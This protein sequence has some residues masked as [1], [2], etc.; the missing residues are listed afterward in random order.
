MQIITTTT[1]IDLIELQTVLASTEFS[2]SCNDLSDDYFTGEIWNKEI[3]VSGE[4]YSL[5]F[6][7]IV[8]NNYNRDTLIEDLKIYD[9]EGDEVEVEN[10]EEVVKYISIKF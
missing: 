2:G 9:S 7:Y 8:R 6:N 4:T 5:D 10:E 3:K 1:K